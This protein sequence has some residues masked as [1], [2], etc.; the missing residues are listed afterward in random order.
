MPSSPASLVTRKANVDVALA[1]EL[2]LE[3]VRPS[4]EAI[5]PSETK[6]VGELKKIPTVHE[7]CTQHRD[8]RGVTEPTGQKKMA[9]RTQD[10]NVKV[11]SSTIGERGDV[12]IFP[13]FGRE[14]HENGPYWGH[15]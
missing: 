1:L 2:V 3:K 6:V 14:R 9:G 8:G 11:T 7:A 10:G 12:T 13:R 5:P 15:T 4:L